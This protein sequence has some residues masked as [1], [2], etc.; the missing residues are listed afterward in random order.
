MGPLMD[1]VREADEH[2]AAAA[3]VEVAVAPDLA[4]C[5][6]A[7][8]NHAHRQVRG[9]DNSITVNRL[10]YCIL[11]VLAPVLTMPADGQL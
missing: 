1:L 4:S 9:T 2:A 6:A 5:A 7:G 11:S 10:R 8:L 3:L